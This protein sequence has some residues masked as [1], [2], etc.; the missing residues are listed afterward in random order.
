MIVMKPVIGVTPSALG[1]N[2]G[3][4][5]INVSVTTDGGNTRVK[6]KEKFYKYHPS[7]PRKQHS[8]KTTHMKNISSNIKQVNIHQTRLKSSETFCS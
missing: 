3:T 5:T 8:K 1:I 2:L 4:R 6:A 7:D